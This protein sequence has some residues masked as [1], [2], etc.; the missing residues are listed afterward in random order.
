MRVRTALER[1][2]SDLAK[3]VRPEHNVER[4]ILDIPDN[5]PDN[6]A[7]LP[8]VDEASKVH[9]AWEER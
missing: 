1:L 5:G 7:F 6:L 9:P 8:K 2:E 4:V 3:V